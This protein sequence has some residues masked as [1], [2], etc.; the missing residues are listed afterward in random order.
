MNSA[1]AGCWRLTE[2][3]PQQKAPGEAGAIFNSLLITI[4]LFQRV[5]DVVVLVITMLS[6]IRL[7]AA[8]IGRSLIQRLL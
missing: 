8:F 4:K 6:A 3:W 5:D 2:A 1:G 7:A